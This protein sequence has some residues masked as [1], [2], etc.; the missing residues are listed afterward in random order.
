[1]AKQNILPHLPQALSVTDAIPYLCMQ[2]DM[3]PNQQPIPRK[4][5]SFNKK[6]THRNYRNDAQSLS[7]SL[8]MF[9]FI[10]PQ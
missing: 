5:T 4:V 9:T 8:F 2:L 3:P 6:E 1:L 7:I 10:D